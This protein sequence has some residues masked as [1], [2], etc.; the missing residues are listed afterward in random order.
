MLKLQP[1]AEGVETAT[2]CYDAPILSDRIKAPSCVH[3]KQVE[4]HCVNQLSP[5]LSDL[6]PIPIELNGVVNKG[7]TCH[8]SSIIQCQLAIPLLCYHIAINEQVVPQDKDVE[9]FEL[10]LAEFSIDSPFVSDLFD[11]SVTYSR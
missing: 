2:S 9:I 11:I 5:S 1:A 4:T 7:N 3:P 6:D 10:V 8:A